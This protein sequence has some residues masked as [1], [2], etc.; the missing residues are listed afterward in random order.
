[1]KELSPTARARYFRRQMIDRLMGG[2][3]VVA[4]GIGLIL[5]GLILWMLFSNGIGGLKLSVF[6]NPMAQPGAEGGLANAIVGSIIQVGIGAM[7]G[8]PIGMMVGVYLSEV[9]KESRFASVV[10]FVNDILLS[11]PSVLIG[12]FVY[13]IAVAPFGGFSGLAGAVSLALIAMPIVARTTED[14]L[15]LVPQAYRDGA[16]ALGSRENEVVRKVVLPAAFGG[17]L[18]G[19]LLAVARIA[20]ETAPLLFTS[21]GNTNWST[22]LTQPMASL[23]IAIYRYAGSPY[24]EWVSLAWTGAMLITVGVLTLNILSRFSHA[25]LAGKQGG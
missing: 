2:L 13:Q 7:I 21:L 23:P 4:A 19:V 20:G 5:L 15:R 22:D 8:A 12:L 17:I 6:T 18:T 11:A 24:P 3:C 9:G 1:M 10:R 25:A 14:I 16:I